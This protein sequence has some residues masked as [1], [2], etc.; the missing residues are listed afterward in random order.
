MLL[1]YNKMFGDFKIGLEKESTECDSVSLDIS[2]N[3]Y[4]LNDACIDDEIEMKTF[5]K[6]ITYDENREEISINKYYVFT[7]TTTKINFYTDYEGKDLFLD[8]DLKTMIGQDIKEEY[9]GQHIYDMNVI[10]YVFK[11]DLNN[12]YYLVEVK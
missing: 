11:N 5:F 12:N 2:T 3:R 10:S 7:K 8:R 1:K 6:N 9:I 4:L